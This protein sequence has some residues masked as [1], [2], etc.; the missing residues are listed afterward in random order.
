MKMQRLLTNVKAIPLA[1]L[2]LVFSLGATLGSHAAEVKVFLM[3]GQSNMLGRAPLSGLPLALQSPQAD[4]LFFGGSDGT[5]GTTLT[6]LRP[7]GKNP[8]EF[9]PE[10][11]FGRAIADASPTTKY[12]LIKYAAGG[13]ALYN[14]W[15]PG[16]GAEYTAFRNTVAAGLAALHAAGHTTEIIGMAWHQGESDAIEGRQANYA[17]NLT[18]FIADI[19]SRYGAGLPFLIGE[20][21]RS[22]GA[23]FVTVADAQ[24]SVASADPK[25]VFIP[26]S[27]LSFLDTY[28]FDAA[29]Q[30]T[31]GQRFAAGYAELAAGSGDSAPPTLN[32]S[33]IIDDKGGTTISPG[34][35]VTYTLTF[36]EDINETTVDANDFDNGGTAAV[37]MGVITEISPGVFTV[38]ARADTTGTLRLR[39]PSGASITDVAG[40]LLDSDPA[41]TDDTTLTVS[42]APAPWITGVSINS[43][44]STFSAARSGENII[45]G[46]GF[47]AASGFHSSAGGD[48]ISWTSASS[49]ATPLPHFVTFD[50]GSSYD[51][52]SVKIWNWNTSSTLTAGS[53]DI[54]ILVAD[55][56][57]GPFTRLGGF[58][59]GI[60]P[61]AG[62]V[63]FGQT[64]DLSGFAAADSVRLLRIEIKSNHGLSNGLSGLSEVRFS[65]SAVPEQTFLAYISD[66][67][68]GLDPE[69][70]GFNDD[71]DGDNIPNGL[72]AW[73]G[74]DPGK[75][76]PGLAGIATNG[77]MSSFTHP[78]NET[79][80]GNVSGLYE[81]SGNLIDWYAGDGV[82]GAPLGPNVTISA[83]TL[84][85]TTTVTATS[86][87][88][89]GNIFFRASAVQE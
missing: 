68:F 70:H 37:T 88:V 45:N 28:H 62:N 40:N 42:S 66:P 30:I 21:R 8:T 34:T 2:G 57:G 80:V 61:G 27:D 46:N 53:K 15:A 47:T 63:D 67:A 25:A 29:S 6:T 64:I 87:E 12:A 85:G 52:G 43:V 11:T 22:N 55:R 77:T 50:L 56:V 79:P 48:N 3:G 23:A 35:T 69:D 60:A 89:L 17:S 65:G 9:G 24:I 10:V 74:T 18:A 33:S 83:N 36:S 73:F 44:S 72:E 49:G 59:L 31:L 7:D 26:A 51:L 81:W 4:V 5:V 1:G 19:R 32:P 20:I 38:E 82:D 54:D 71:P 13:T 75:S 58:V 14:D 84:N 16:T 41:I 76:D 78:Q 39:V 86:S